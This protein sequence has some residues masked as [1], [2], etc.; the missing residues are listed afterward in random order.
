MKLASLQHG[1]DGRL[2]VVRRDL[3]TYVLAEPIAQ[4]LQEALDNWHTAAP[5]LVALATALE[6]GR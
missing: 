4:T 6:Q 5:Q 2:I 1:R 3:K